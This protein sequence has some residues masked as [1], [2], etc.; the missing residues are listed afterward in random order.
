MTDGFSEKAKQNH[1]REDGVKGKETKKANMIASA[2]LTTTATTTS[3]TISPYACMLF[4]SLC[5][6]VYEFSCVVFPPVSH[7]CNTIPDDAW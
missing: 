1:E 2:P 6:R 7:V 5:V 4:V 3:T